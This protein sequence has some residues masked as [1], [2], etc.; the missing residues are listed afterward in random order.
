MAPV[1]SSGE[2]TSR[3]IT[4]S[5]STGPASRSAAGGRLRAGD[6]EGDLVGIDRVHGG[7]QQRRLHVDHRVA[8]QRPA[9]QAPRGRRARRRRRTPWAACRRPARSRTG[10]GPTRGRARWLARRR[11]AAP[12]AP[13]PGRTARGR[14]RRGRRSPRGSAAAGD[15]LAVGHLGPADVGLDLELA[16]QAVDDD[17]QVQ[18]AH[19]R[20]SGSGRS[21]RRSTRGSEGSS[22]ASFSSAPPSSSWPAWVLGSITTDIAGGGN[23]ITSR[24]TGAFR[25][26]RV[27]PVVVTRSPTAA[28]MLPQATA[29]RTSSFLLACICS[30]RPMR[31]RLPLVAL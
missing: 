18:L 15:A 4:G 10:S 8:G 16:H 31:S 30:R 23:S 22:A 5:S 24:T 14:R 25:S 29:S 9:P 28:A 21:R 26:H 7:R 19:A 6:L 12:A 1:N 2:T 3:A 11:A 17:L 13:S 27:S 20:R